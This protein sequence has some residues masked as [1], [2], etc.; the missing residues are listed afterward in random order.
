MQSVDRL[1]S[2]IDRRIEA[3]GNVR[4]PYVIV[5]CFRYTDHV[6]ANISQHPGRL[7]RAIASDANQT[8]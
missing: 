5:D 1:G 4:T 6:Q 3:K 8:I 7:L 2:D